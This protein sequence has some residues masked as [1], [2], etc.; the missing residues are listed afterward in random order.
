[1]SNPRFIATSHGRTRM[2]TRLAIICLAAVACCA[3]PVLGAA[4]RSTTGSVAAP[5]STRIGGPVGAQESVQGMQRVC[6]Y[7]GGSSGARTRTYRVGL[8]QRC[9]TTYPTVDPSQPPPPTASLQGFEDTEDGRECRYGSGSRTWTITL[10]TTATCPVNAGMAMD[11]E[12]A[13]TE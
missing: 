3:S 5:L 13:S 1:M 7:S 11:V 2:S 4:P 8:A 9:P 12:G 10:P 6:T